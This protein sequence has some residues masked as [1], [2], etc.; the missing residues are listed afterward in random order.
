MNDKCLNKLWG[1]TK[2]LNI[3]N[4]AASSINAYALRWHAFDLRNI[5]LI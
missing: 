5:D 1:L 2:S 3:Y 4:A